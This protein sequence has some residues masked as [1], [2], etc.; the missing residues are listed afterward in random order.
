MHQ[1]VQMSFALAWCLLSG[2]TFV[3]SIFSKGETLTISLMFAMDVM[4]LFCM[5]NHYQISELKQSKA[6]SIWLLE[7]MKKLHMKKLLACSNQM[8]QIKNLVICK[9]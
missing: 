5:L 1:K 6:V 7:I 4:T 3:T 9:K 2:V 8:T